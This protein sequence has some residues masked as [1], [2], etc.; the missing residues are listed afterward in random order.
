[1]NVEGASSLAPQDPALPAADQAPPP[2]VLARE[3]S[4]RGFLNR[5]SLALCGV[6]AAAVGVPVLSY[7]ITPLLRPS[8]QEWFSMGPV[9]GFQVGQTVLKSLPDVS[10][11]AWAGQVA[12]SAIW[13]RRTG[14]QAF[15]V[16]AI[17]CTHLG[18]PVNWR[19]DANLFM[20]PCHGGVYYS[21]G[22]VAGGPPPRPLFQYETRIQAGQLQVRT[23][24]IGIG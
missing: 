11:V 16:F 1:V 20:C 7:I 24:P 14:D 5:I 4:R 23:R 10:P 17:N 8:P 22:T 18:C 15:T 19:A 2:E 6:A 9:D 3:A 21:D 13:V 12:E